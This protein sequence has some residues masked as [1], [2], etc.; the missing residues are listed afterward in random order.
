VDLNAD[1]YNDILSGSYS[2]HETAMAGL[3]Q[4]LW[5]QRDGTFKPAEALEGTDGE[6]LI[7][8]VVSR[9]KDPD[10]WIN[11]ICTRPTGV[12]WDADGDLDLVVGNFTGTFYLFTGEGEGRFAPKPGIIDSGDSPLKIQGNHSDPFLVDW[13]ADGDLD[14]ISGSSNGGVQ[15]SENGAG[16]GKPPELKPFQTLIEPGRQ[17]TPGQTLGENDLVGPASATRV[18]VDD[19]NSDGKLDILV[20]DSVTLVSPAKGIGEEELSKRFAKWQKDLEAASKE[21]NGSEA[22]KRNEAILRWQSLYQ[23]REEFMTEERT[24]FVWLYR[25][26]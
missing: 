26:K 23:Q 12:D 5:G 21:M 11:N 22:G 8:P 6:P 19:V 2:R 16:S 18:W 20:G 24:G 4:V 3:Y 7:I 17:S 13:D 15:W 10:D 25:R 14:L 9:E 1:G